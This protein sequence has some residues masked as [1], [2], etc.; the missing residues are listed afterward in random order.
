MDVG[1]GMIGTCIPVTFIVGRGTF[2]A[3]SLK[4]RTES[5]SEEKW[6]EVE[7]IEFSDVSGNW[8]LLRNW[9]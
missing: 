8:V 9:A 7:I 3:F 4:S 5:S 2:D 1:S 6:K